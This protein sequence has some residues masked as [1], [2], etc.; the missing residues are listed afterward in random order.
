MPIMSEFEY[1]IKYAKALMS[2]FQSNE[3]LRETMCSLTRKA[4]DAG[5]V[6]FGSEVHPLLDRCLGSVTN[7]CC[8]EGAA[9]REL[10]QCQAEVVKGYYEA[11]DTSDWVSGMSQCMNRFR[12]LRSQVDFETVCKRFIL[13]ATDLVQSGIMT[14]DEFARFVGSI[15]SG[16]KSHEDYAGCLILFITLGA[17]LCWWFWA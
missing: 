4:I 10:N 14:G 6:E 8:L 7:W 15:D 2:A 11:F 5:Y 9:G 17:V 12:P 3:S 1:S 13:H 16:K